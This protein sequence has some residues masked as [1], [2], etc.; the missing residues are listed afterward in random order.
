MDQ[1]LP[2]CDGAAIGEVEVVG[3]GTGSVS[4]AFENRAGLG[5]FRKRVGNLL[6]SR[7]VLFADYSAVLV[8]ENVLESCASV[9][10]PGLTTGSTGN[11]RTVTSLNSLEP[12][13]RLECEVV[14]V[15]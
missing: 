4:V 13:S 9:E 10:V 7:T 14:A 5:I 12:I 15:P 8:E 3:L 6:Q 2:H 11:L 1:R